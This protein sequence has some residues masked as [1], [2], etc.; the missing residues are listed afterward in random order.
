VHTC[1]R[2]CMFSY[3]RACMRGLAAWGPGRPGLVSGG[4]ASGKGSFGGWIFGSC[5]NSLLLAENYKLT[6][7][8]NTTEAQSAQRLNGGGRNSLLLDIL[9]S[10]GLASPGSP[11]I[12][13]TALAGVQG[14]RSWVP[15]LV[16]R[17]RPGC[18]AVCRTGAH[19]CSRMGARVRV[20]LPL[21]GREN[22]IAGKLTL[23]QG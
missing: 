19:A 20:W 23:F 12:V 15:P 11:S 1:W 14:S 9:A 6:T 17:G 16:G 3:G 13:A 7:T 22:L 21:G 18:I 8:N 2:L 10:C 5:G 4:L